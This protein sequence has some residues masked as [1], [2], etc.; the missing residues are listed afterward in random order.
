MYC[1]TPS[2]HLK[3]STLTEKE[4]RTL[5]QPSI[6]LSILQWHCICP[7]LTLPWA[8]V[9]SST[10]GAG[11]AAAAG[12]PAWAPGWGTGYWGSST[13]TPGS[14][15][16]RRPHSTPCTCQHRWPDWDTVE[17]ATGQQGKGETDSRRR[18]HFYMQTW[19][20][21]KSIKWCQQY[22][23]VTR[24]NETNKQW[25]ICYHGVSLH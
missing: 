24:K 20:N 12:P 21:I 17:L 15:R 11:V 9:G 8:M 22:A 19:G 16:W 1:R 14:C 4:R 3:S 7:P 2:L 6:H 23:C 5:R 18:I 13:G 25:W 10:A